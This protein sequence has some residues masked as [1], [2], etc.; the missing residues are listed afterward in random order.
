M[1]V[2]KEPPTHGRIEAVQDAPQQSRN[3]FP[4]SLNSF[5][6]Q[7]Y[8]PGD[9]REHPG[10]P[11]LQSTKP[12]GLRLRVA[13]PVSRPVGITITG[14]P[15]GFVPVAQHKIHHTQAGY[16]LEATRASYQQDNRKAVDQVI[17]EHLHTI[18]SF[19]AVGK[20]GLPVRS[21]RHSR[22]DMAAERASL[23]HNRE[24]NYMQ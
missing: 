10:V 2:T 12:L 8:F 17:T 14:S 6:A 20:G 18:P 23:F 1:P 21:P 5:A 19:P 15:S 4:D 9:L 24:R 11:H 16:W 7:N 3:L 22:K 13:S